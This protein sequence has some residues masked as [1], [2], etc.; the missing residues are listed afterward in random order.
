M[1]IDPVGDVGVVVYGEA[2]TGSDGFAGSVVD[3]IE[4]ESSAFD[5]FP[6]REGMGDGLVFVGERWGE[7]EKGAER[8]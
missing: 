6:V 1:S 5:G 3:N 4:L 2:Y 7:R 8:D